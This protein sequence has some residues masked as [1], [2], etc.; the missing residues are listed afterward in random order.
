MRPGR[1]QMLSPLFSEVHLK[2]KITQD[3]GIAGEHTEAGQV[4]DIPEN[5]AIAVVNMGKA[6]PYDGKTK[7]EDRSVGLTTET[8]SPIKKRSR[9]K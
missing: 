8:A 1:V 2:I 6:T 4:V 3:C 9:K 7:T 5:E